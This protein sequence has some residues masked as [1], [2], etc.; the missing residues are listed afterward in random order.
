MSFETR[1]ICLIAV[2][3]LEIILVSFLVGEKRKA[4]WFKK[5]S[6]YTL[7]TQRSGLG[8]MLHFGHPVTIEGYLVTVTLFVLIAISAYLLFSL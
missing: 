7:F 8:E 1:A 4:L 5:R 3:L 2:A 6:N